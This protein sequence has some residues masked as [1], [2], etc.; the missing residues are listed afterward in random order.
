MWRR[1]GCIS[2]ALSGISVQVG[3]PSG[4]S[5][6]P[7]WG[8]ITGLQNRVCGQ[9]KVGDGVQGGEGDLLNLG[10]VVLHVLVEYKFLE[11]V[12]GG[13]GMQPDLDEVEDVI[14][15]GLGL[16][17]GHRLLKGKGSMGTGHT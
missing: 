10:K 1:S 17:G 13:G 16:H 2:C 15:E 5:V 14:V 7:S 9:V 4:G 12:P 8:T 11:G 3:C 6:C